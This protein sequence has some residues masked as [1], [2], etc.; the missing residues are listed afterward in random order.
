MN[1]KL[2]I[3]N[4]MFFLAS[5]GTIIPGTSNRASDHL[6]SQD[7]L[8]IQVKALI[9]KIRQD[10]KYDPK[11]R[12]FLSDCTFYKHSHTDESTYMY[13]FI[14]ARCVIIVTDKTSYDSTI[15]FTSNTC[16]FHGNM[17]HYTVFYPYE[18]SATTWERVTYHEAVHLVDFMENP[19]CTGD[20]FECRDNAEYLAYSKTLPFFQDYLLN[21]GFT[22]NDIIE[23]NLD[24]PDDPLIVF[25]NDV[26]I[27]TIDYDVIVNDMEHLQ[28]FLKGDLYD[29]IQ[30]FFS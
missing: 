23:A 19:T 12:T 28:H 5:C 4:M 29:H 8:F 15:A 27:S 13:K 30:R 3:L 24:S 10:P 16:G 18:L 6:T 20:P 11:I 25:A 14:D 1:T 26:A 9:E 21:Y 7:K 17:I 2:M 22:A